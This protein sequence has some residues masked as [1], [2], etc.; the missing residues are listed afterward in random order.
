MQVIS[1]RFLESLFAVRLRDADELIFGKE[2]MDEF[3]PEPL[4]SNQPIPLW[5]EADIWERLKEDGKY[6]SL[7]TGGGI[8]HA[9]IG[10]RVTK[11]QA[12]SIIRY[13]VKTGCEHF[14][15]ELYIQ[16]VKMVT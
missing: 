3:Y 11:K 12:K 2:K 10:E 4:Y 16:N 8:V 14:C 7:I 9:T 13:S 1:S 6:N 15:I 5:H